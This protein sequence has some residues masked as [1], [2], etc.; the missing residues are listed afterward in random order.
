[1]SPFFIA[2]QKRAVLEV[3]V[4][5]ILNQVQD[6]SFGIYAIRSVEIPKRIRSDTAN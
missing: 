4:M 2:E 3:S 6:D 5:L 1:M